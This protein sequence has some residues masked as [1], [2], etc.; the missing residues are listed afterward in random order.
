M[1][2]KFFHLEFSLLWLF[3]HIWFSEVKAN[4]N[5]CWDVSFFYKYF[6]NN[7]IYKQSSYLYF[8]FMLF[9]LNPF[10]IDNILY[11][12]NKKLL[13]CVYFLVKLWHDGEQFFLN[14]LWIDFFLEFQKSIIHQFIPCTS[15]YIVYYVLTFIDS[16]WNREQTGSK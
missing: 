9:P 2:Y 16:E 1:K 13:V 15:D 8:Y 4:Y 5:F 10:L 3:F 12:L 7:K 6:H 14:I 11:E